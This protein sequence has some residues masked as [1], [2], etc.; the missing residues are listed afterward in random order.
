MRI[1]TLLAGVACLL[2]VLLDALADRVAARIGL[3]TE[4]TVY[5]SLDL[6]PCCTRR[7]FREVAPRIPEATKQGALWIVPRVAWDAYR[8]RRSGTARRVEASATTPDLDR[9]ADELLRE[10][11]LRVVRGAR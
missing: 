3:H 10:A 9:Q 2:G 7:R 4:R 11:G 6:P 1:L 5:T 8:T